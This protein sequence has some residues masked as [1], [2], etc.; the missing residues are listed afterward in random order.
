MAASDWS[1]LGPTYSTEITVEYSPIDRGQRDKVR[2]GNVLV[3]PVH[4]LV[5]EAELDHRAVFPDEAGI[6]GA[7]RCG[8]HRLA[9]GHFGDR[10]AHQIDE[11]SRGGD[12]GVGVGRIPFDT[13]ASAAGPGAGACLDQG[14]ERVA[15][16]AIV[17]PDVE[18]RSRLGRN[19]V[20][21]L[22]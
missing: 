9:P 5:D 11:R 10:V 7:S 15:A 8:Q 20:A 21:R 13:E 18:A 17:I 1:F 14:L 16:V 4:G 2:G 6:G 22:V 12:E 3:D 19:D